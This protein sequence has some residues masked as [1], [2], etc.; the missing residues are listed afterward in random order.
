MRGRLTRS[1]G[2]RG[3]KSLQASFF[4]IGA[5]T[6]GLLAVRFGT[7]FYLNFLAAGLLAGAIALTRLLRALL[8]EV[9]PTDPLTFVAVAVLLGIIAAAAAFA[10][11]RRAA[12]VDPLVVLRSE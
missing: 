3:E 6:S 9:T 11:A 8:F 5:Y 2:A 10:P 7:P 4:G 12:R 1:R